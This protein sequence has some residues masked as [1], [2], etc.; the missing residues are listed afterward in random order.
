MCVTVCVFAFLVGVEKAL[1]AG[2]PEMQSSVLNACMSYEQWHLR[3]MH[4]L[5]HLCVPV[6]VHVCLC[7]RVLAKKHFAHAHLAGQH[8]PV[9]IAA[10]GASASDRANKKDI[11][12][13]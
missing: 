1:P 5:V 11:H 3:C 6:C 7:V 2:V 4:V 12:Q 9:S 8:V 13:N 10:G